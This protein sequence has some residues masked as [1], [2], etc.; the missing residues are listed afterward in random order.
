MCFY[1][2]T[3]QMAFTCHISGVAAVVFPWEGGG[4][5]KTRINVSGLHTP[6]MFWSK[7]DK[8]EAL[9]K[10]IHDYVSEEPR[11]HNV[12]STF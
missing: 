6:A 12:T 9:T 5:G 2:T 4:A 1:E 11:Y 8:P 10:T 3:Q 7:L